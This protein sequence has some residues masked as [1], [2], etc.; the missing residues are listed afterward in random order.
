V[1]REP[2]RHETLVLGVTGVA[3]SLLAWEALGRLGL[4]DPLVFASPSRVAGAL[5]RQWRSGELLADLATSAA[6]FAVAFGLA[7]G[8]G[9]ALGLAMGLWRDARAALEPIVWGLYSA[10]LVVF[11]PL[12]VVWLGF[13]FW[14]VVALA[15]AL[16]ALPIAVN[17][18]AGV[19]GVD[20]VLRRAVR[21]F[22]G[23]RWHEVAKVIVPASIPLVLAGLRIGAGR[24]LVGV[25]VGEMFGANAG[26]GFRLHH[27]GAR[28]R[29][30]D[31][32]VP[33]LGV[34]AIGL[35]ATQAVRLGERWAARGRAT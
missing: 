35:L 4:I 21:A 3:G 1:S 23:R 20:P 26:L 24:A 10:P 25:V 8:V 5:G 2:A 13:G 15:A 28:L 32:L 30:A 27:Y 17:T 16:A 33:L 12:L 29:S 9:V 14:T 31:V 18:Q 22:G 6:E 7:V 34:V 11:Q 19:Q